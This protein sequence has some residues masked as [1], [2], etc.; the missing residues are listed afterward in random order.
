MSEPRNDPPAGPAGSTDPLDRSPG[1]AE[2]DHL[3]AAALAD[4]VRMPAPRRLREQLARQHLATRRPWR[5]WIPAFALGAAAAAAIALLVVRAP[6]GDVAVLDEIVGD[7]MR[8]V[9]AE[10]PLDVETNDLHNVKPWFTPRLDFVPP[11]NFIGNEEFPL[12]GGSLAVFQGHR[13]AAFVYQHRL[14]IITVLVYPDPA[15]RLRSET[16]SRGFH[17]I[18]WSVAG[19]GIALVSD[20]SWDDLR[21]L[22]THVR[23]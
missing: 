3:I 5:A 6:A 20:V 13:A 12:R 16:T 23:S 18:S 9:S 19:F 11:V 22:E 10:H 17:V 4:H 1:V 14:H 15:T 2:A 8:I 21:Q 7:H